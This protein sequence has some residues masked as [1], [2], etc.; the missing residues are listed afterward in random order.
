MVGCD[1][2]SGHQ[3]LPFILPAQATI[4]GDEG[5]IVEDADASKFPRNSA[6]FAIDAV[7]CFRLT[8]QRLWVQD[9]R[10]D[11]GRLLQGV[12]DEGSLTS[13]PKCLEPLPKAI[14]N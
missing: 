11:A 6:E 10:C 12:H 7:N 14:A 8:G 3:P 13:I 4:A 5:V 1:W 2:H 9:A